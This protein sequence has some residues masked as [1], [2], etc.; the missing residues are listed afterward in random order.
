MPPRCRRG[1]PGRDR[2]RCWR[3]WRPCCW[4]R[5]RAG[6]HRR[7]PARPTSATAGRA[8]RSRSSFHRARRPAAARDA[9]GALRGRA[10][11]ALRRPRPA[12]LAGRGTGRPARRARPLGRLAVL[13]RARPARAGTRPARRCGSAARSAEVPVRSRASVGAEPEPGPLLVDEYDTTVVVP[14]G[15][16]VRRHDEHRDA[17]ARAGGRAWLSC[18][19]SHA[20]VRV[21]SGDAADRRERPAV[22]RRRDGDDDHPHRPLDRRPRRNG[23]LVGAL[24][25][26]GRDD[27]AGGQRPLP[28]RLDPDRDGSRCSATTATASGRATSSS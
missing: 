23:L 25:R 6:P 19:R 7:G 4:A 12:R 28:P 20:T 26:A 18:G 3:R 24:R 1:R 15:W 2:R 11:A 21:R 27:R 13:R 14:D 5:S 8:G 16:S 10:R 22:D 9:A 17:R